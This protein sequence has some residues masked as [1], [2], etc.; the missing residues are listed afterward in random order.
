MSGKCRGFSKIGIVGQ[1]SCWGKVPENSS[2]NCID[3][4]FC[5]TRLVLCVILCC[6]LLNVAYLCFLVFMSVL[7]LS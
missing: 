7:Y 5:I 1:K 2:K 3:R 6:F 4:L